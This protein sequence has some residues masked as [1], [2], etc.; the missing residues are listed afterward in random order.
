MNRSSTNNIIL[1]SLLAF[2]LA[3]N[4]KGPGTSHVISPASPVPGNSFGLDKSPMDMSYYPH[5]YP[6]LKMSGNTKQD[7]I[8]RVIYSR[9]HKDGRRIFGEVVK[10]GVPW[11]LGA[12]EATEI[13][14]FRDVT[15]SGKKVPKGR[16]TLYCVPYQN[17]WKLILNDDLFTWGLKIDRSKDLFAFEEPVRKND[18]PVEVLTLEFEQSNNGMDLIMAWDTVKVILPVTL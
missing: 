2:S 13:E 8:A 3:C 9:P 11:R 10:Y 1:S 14:F 6:I 16:Y 15:I 17:N 18:L 4:T 5:D 7:L 12:N